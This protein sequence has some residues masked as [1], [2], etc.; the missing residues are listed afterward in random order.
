MRGMR[1]AANH[2]PPMRSR[3]DFH[4]EPPRRPQASEIDE[5]EPPP[6]RPRHVEMRGGP[7]GG[8]RGFEPEFE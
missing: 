7:R 4:V 3:D 1:G 2:P 5:L 6:M 8:Y